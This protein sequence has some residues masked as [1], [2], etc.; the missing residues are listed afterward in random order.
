MWQEVGSGAIGAQAA[1]EPVREHL[2]RQRDLGLRMAGHKKPPLSSAPCYGPGVDPL[3]AARAD[4]ARFSGV[5]SAERDG[6]AIGVEAAGRAD[7]E[8]FELAG[9]LV[10][11]GLQPVPGVVGTATTSSERE[12]SGGEGGP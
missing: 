10:T 6:V 7:A 1:P 2:G 11:A 9:E 5:V 12:L 4:P 3:E 8:T